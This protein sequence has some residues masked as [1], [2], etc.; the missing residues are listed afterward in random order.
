MGYNNNTGEYILWGAKHT[1]KSSNTPVFWGTHRGKKRG[2]GVKKAGKR[3]KM[4]GERKTKFKKGGVCSQ[5][6][7]RGGERL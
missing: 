5:A 3:G 1:G 6:R 4:W 2:G 7:K